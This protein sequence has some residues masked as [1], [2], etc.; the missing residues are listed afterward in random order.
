MIK[1]NISNGK[2]ILY[3]YQANNTIVVKE[4]Y[5]SGVDY[6]IETPFTWTN[7][8]ITSY[9]RNGNNYSMSYDTKNNPIYMPFGIEADPIWDN[10]FCV[11]SSPYMHNWSKNNVISYSGNAY[12]GFSLSFSFSYDNKNYPTRLVMGASKTQITYYN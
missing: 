2:E 4:Q 5:Y 3:E 6:Y 1:Q 9:V 10:F 12:G 11:E 7:S 8:N